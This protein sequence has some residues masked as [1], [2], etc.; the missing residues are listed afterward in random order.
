LAA[1]AALALLSH[2]M[3]LDPMVNFLHAAL[4]ELR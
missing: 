4:M 1:L 2:M 3:R